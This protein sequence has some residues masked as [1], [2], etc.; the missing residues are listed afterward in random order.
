MAPQLVSLLFSNWPKFFPGHFFFNKNPRST[1]THESFVNMFDVEHLVLGDVNRHNQPSY[2]L[3]SAWK[4]ISQIGS[5]P[6]VR[7]KQK[8]SSKPPRMFKLFD[9]HPPQKGLNTSH[10]SAG[11]FHGRIHQRL[12]KTNSEFTP[13]KNPSRTSNN[14]HHLIYIHPAWKKRWNQQLL[15]FC[16]SFMCCN[17]R[18]VEQRFS[19]INIP[20]ISEIMHP[21]RNLPQFLSGF[22]VVSCFLK[23]PPFHP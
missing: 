4:N 15:F 2:L 19:C 8:K 13:E 14:D 20:V 21:V 22:L 23:W 5:L 6:Q 1:K 17:C 7:V 3:I 10:S 9:S 12:H 18:H 11:K 16:W